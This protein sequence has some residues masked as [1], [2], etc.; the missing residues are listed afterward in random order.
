LDSWNYRVIRKGGRYAIHKVYYNEQRQIWTCSEDPVYPEGKTLEEL[1]ED[2]ERYHLALREPI[3][4][5]A[6]LVPDS[7]W[8]D[9]DAKLPF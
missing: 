2:L 9:P 5:C 7:E 1:C 8:F 6:D 3:L 4:E